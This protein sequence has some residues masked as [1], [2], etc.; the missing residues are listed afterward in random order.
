MAVKMAAEPAAGAAVR[1]G[2]R[3]RSRLLLV[4]LLL[5][6]GGV[7]MVAPFL[8]MILTSFKTLPESL[9]VPPEIL[10]GSWQFENF[11]KVWGKN[12]F[13]RYYL[14]SILVTAARTAGQLL[15]C[16]LAAFAFA[17]LRFPGK[18]L[19]FI[20]MLSVLMVPSQ[21]VLIPNF[22]LMQQFRWLDT[23]YALIV[24]GIFSAFGTFL[25]R[26]FFMGLP[27]DLDEAA[28][29]DG[30][31]LFGIYWRIYLP[32]SKPALVA[33]AIFT[34]LAAWNDFFFPLIM[35]SS[36]SMRV[37]PVGI[38]NFQGQYTTDYPLL[39]AGALLAT[40]PMILMFIFLQRYFIEG[41]AMTG[42]KG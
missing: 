8:W 40:L 26:Q 10:P 13:G 9:K 37:L 38:A 17:R 2:S 19:L 33:L 4:H 27:K 35:T 21:V 29:I 28:K 20:G 14:N 41:I 36:D 1:T 22:I 30:C 12:N 34:I 24:P 5:V 42:T 18:N 32:L 31:S 39:M 11:T 16:S 7:V 15:L 25:L 6:A 23:F 3:D